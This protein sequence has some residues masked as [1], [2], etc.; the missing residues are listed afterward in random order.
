MISNKN[1]KLKASEVFVPGGFP[2]ITYN[3]RSDKSLENN[4]REAADNLSKLCIVTGPTK[5]GKTV[6]VDR[7]FPRDCS[8]WI[9]SGMVNDENS[10]WELVIEQLDGYT[11]IEQQESDTSSSEIGLNG[12]LEANAIVLKGTAN[13]QAKYSSGNETSKKQRRASG[14][15]TVALSIL[16]KQQIPLII[17]DFHYLNKEIQRQ[18]VRAVKSPIMH[19]LPVIFI[20]IPNR[21][22]DTVEVEREMTGRINTIAMPSWEKGELFQIAKLGFDSLKIKVDE[23]MLTQLVEEAYGSP[24]LMQEFCRSICKSSGIIEEY[25]QPTLFSKELDLVT[26]FSALADNSG[27]PVFDKLKRGPRAR[28]DRKIRTLKSGMTTDI[29]GLVMESLKNIKPGV[30]SLNYED[31]RNNIRSILLDNPPQKNEVTRVLD[32]IA[33]I[34]YTA[35]SSTPVIDWQ[36]DDNMLTITDPFF[37]FYLKWAN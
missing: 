26:I 27:R 1:K 2:T 29:Y 35:N 33:Q 22:Y 20:A 3:P 19:G 14:N 12:G 10:F 32:K 5:S 9:D 18:I 6:L 24:F 28:S 7:I 21:K 31:L 8:V 30:E 17:D 23:C 15:K 36:K 4:V 16:Q 13:L 34:S 25:S 37:A 11:E